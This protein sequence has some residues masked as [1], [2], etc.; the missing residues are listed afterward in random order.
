[1]LGKFFKRLLAGAAVALIG[2]AVGKI[3]EKLFP[4][5]E[6]IEA[7]A[8]A[9]TT[10]TVETKREGLAKVESKQVA[11]QS[12]R[13]PAKAAEKKF[14]EVVD[15]DYRILHEE[16][17]QVFHSDDE[18][19][20]HGVVSDRVRDQILM[21]AFQ[22]N[23]K[24]VFDR[25]ALTKRLQDKIEAVVNAA[26]I[27]WAKIQEKKRTDAVVRAE[28]LRLMGLHVHNEMRLTG[29]A[30]ATNED[31]DRAI[32]GIFIEDFADKNVRV[33][34]PLIEK[35]VLEQTPGTKEFYALHG[36]KSGG[37]VPEGYL[38]PRR[39][40]SKSPEQDAALI[41]KWKYH[42]HKPVDLVQYECWEEQRKERQRLLRSDEYCWEDPD[43]TWKYPLWANWPWDVKDLYAILKDHFEGYPG[44]GEH[45]A[46]VYFTAM[47][48]ARNQ[49]WN[50]GRGRVPHY[51]SEALFKYCVFTLRKMLYTTESEGAFEDNGYDQN[52]PVADA[53]EKFLAYITIPNPRVGDGLHYTPMVRIGKSDDKKKV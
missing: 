8:L 3:A 36:P 16:S 21:E 4:A 22:E 28:V 11:V 2:F 34:R 49:T 47:I 38:V 30:F 1:M 40:L 15:V 23:P 53:F 19:L 32:R 13:G 48:A 41:R 10:A 27:K 33:L 51:L 50:A 17:G 6:A 42:I 18:A 43:D 37:L 31:V 7:P 9:M 20:A 24:L 25:Q 35:S 45:D 39:K 46:M 29:K 12:P 14:T 52:G 5:K 26:K 44:E